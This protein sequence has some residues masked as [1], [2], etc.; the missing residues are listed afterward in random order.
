[1]MDQFSAIDYAVDYHDLIAMDDDA[2][3]MILHRET[4]LHGEIQKAKEEQRLAKLEEER[5]AEIARK[6]EVERLRLQREEQEKQAAELARQQAEFRAEQERVAEE[7]R[8][9]EKAIADEAAKIKATQE[10]LEKS[11]R[12]EIVRIEAERK[13]AEDHLNEVTSAR[14]ETL[15]SYGYTYPFDD[16]GT[17]SQYNYDQL[18]AAHRKA[19]E[20]KLHEEWLKAQQKKKEEEETKRIAEEQRL[21]TIEADRVASLT[22][23]QKIREFGNEIDYLIATLPIVT[24]KSA[25][26]LRDSIFSLL[27]QASQ[28]CKPEI[29]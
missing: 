17:M 14:F 2:F 23:M 19:H 28:K 12:E 6:E 27:E 3:Q 8:K 5:L 7:Q 13:S 9:R 10:A 16:L 22:D 18:E 15:K 24:S 20:V 29:K 26:S 21:A 25:S 4:I 1:M 11:K